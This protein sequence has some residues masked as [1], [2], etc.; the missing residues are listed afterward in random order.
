[1][2]TYKEY[3]CLTLEEV[4]RITGPHFKGWAV[5]LIPADNPENILGELAGEDFRLSEIIRAHPEL[6]NCI[7]KYSNDFYGQIVL[8]VAKHTEGCA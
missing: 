1:M 3:H 7:V 4:A 5:F 8:R 6:A 2:D